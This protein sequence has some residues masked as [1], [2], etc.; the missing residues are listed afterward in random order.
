LRFAG[1]HVDQAGGRRR[2][3]EQ[4]TAELGTKH[5]EQLFA[6]SKITVLARGV[7]YMQ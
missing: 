4:W 2:R 7:R 6:L 3:Y 1:L 5:D